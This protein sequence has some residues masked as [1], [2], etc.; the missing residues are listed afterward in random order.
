[1]VYDITST[2][3]FD[4]LESWKEEYILNGSP[5][6]PENFP[7]IVL[8]NKSDKIDEKKVLFLLKVDFTKV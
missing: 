2:K 5:K 4:S 6:D 1:L 7:F 8:G 3:S